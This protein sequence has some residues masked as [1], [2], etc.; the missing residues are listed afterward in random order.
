MKSF[1][2]CVLTLS[3]V[4]FFM[5]QYVYHGRVTKHISMIGFYTVFAMTLCRLTEQMFLRFSGHLT[6]KKDFCPL[7]N[8]S[9]LQSMFSNSLNQCFSNIFQN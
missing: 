9:M 5:N 2:N 4:S 7:G 6:K 1:K 8:K 3:F